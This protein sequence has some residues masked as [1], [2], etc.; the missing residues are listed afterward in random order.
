M[1]TVMRLLEDLVPN[2]PKE[3]REPLSG[4]TFLAAIV[5]NQ[6]GQV[7]ERSYARAAFA[8][9]IKIL[10]EKKDT[11]EL[12]DL[13]KKAY[14]ESEKSFGQKEKEAAVTNNDDNQDEE[15]P[16]HTTVLPARICR[17]QD[18]GIV[19]SGI[20][21]VK[22]SF[23]KSITTRDYASMQAELATWNKKV[24]NQ[25][26]HRVT[27]Q[28]PVE[29]YLS[30]EKARLQPLPIVR[31]DIYHHEQRVVNTFGHIYYQYNQYSVPHH[32]RRISLVGQ[33]ASHF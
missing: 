2:R 1:E 19:E 26:V 15:N 10:K 32:Q 24:C 22:N 5:V 33:P 25:R 3:Y 14:T 18:K 6:Q 7:V 23:L 29:I 20:K 16:D 31:Y 13:L 8:Y 30:Q 28:I 21:Y 17:G 11:E 9:G 12:S 27:R 4:L